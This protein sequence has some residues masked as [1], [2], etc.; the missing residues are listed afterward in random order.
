MSRRKG[1]KKAKWT[2]RLRSTEEA[3]NLY[4]VLVAFQE[5]DG[6]GLINQEALRSV[7]RWA[8]AIANQVPSIGELATDKRGPFREKDYSPL[9]A[10]LILDERERS[11]ML[12]VCQVIYAQLLT[13]EGK[14][15]WIENQGQKD[16]DM[17]VAGYQRWIRTLEREPL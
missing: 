15:G 16:Y 13:P 2:L 1:K 10:L 7:A 6:G 5:S 12:F 4:S 17:A 11:L 9:N 8:D 14:R 3:L